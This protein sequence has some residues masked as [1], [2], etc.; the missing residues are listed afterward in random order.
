MVLF[1][2]VGFVHQFKPCDPNF[3]STS[4]CNVFVIVS[5][6]LFIIVRYL[7]HQVFLIIRSFSLTE[8][9]LSKYHD[10]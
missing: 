8:F 7:D 6:S 9:K 2:A 10:Y 4:I 5:E 3:R 1:T